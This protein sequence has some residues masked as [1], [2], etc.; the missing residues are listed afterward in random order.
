MGVEPVKVVLLSN[1]VACTL[2]WGD[3]S[4][5]VTQTIHMLA[6]VAFLLVGFML[7]LKQPML[8]AS[9]HARHC[10]CGPSGAWRCH[11]GTV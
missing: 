7:M 10:N 9:M 5:V 6:L 11:R 8:G 2:V 1:V 4:L 3:A